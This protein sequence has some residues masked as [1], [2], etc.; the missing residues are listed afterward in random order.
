MK[1]EKRKGKDELPVETR[2][3]AAPLDPSISSDTQREWVKKQGE[4][5]FGLA[6]SAEAILAFNPNLLLR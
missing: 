5:E 4:I 3:F 2:C 1:K 6:T